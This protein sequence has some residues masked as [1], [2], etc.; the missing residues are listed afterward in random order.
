MYRYDAS[1]TIDASLLSI[2]CC[3]LACEKQKNVPV[4]AVLYR[5]VR[6]PRVFRR[7]NHRSISNSEKASTGLR[8]LGRE[9]IQSKAVKSMSRKKRA[10]QENVL[11]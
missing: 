2:P 6:T 11:N 10:A 7:D 4:R 8:A 5:Y 1:S 9:T 3:G